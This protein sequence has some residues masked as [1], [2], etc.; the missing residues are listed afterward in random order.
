ME[1]LDPLS[2]FGSPIRRSTLSNCTGDYRDGEPKML[3]S[4]EEESSNGDTCSSDNQGA[5]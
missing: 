4:P 2:S 1:D 5:N 3:L